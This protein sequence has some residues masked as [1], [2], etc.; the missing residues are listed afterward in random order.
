MKLIIQ[1]PCYNEENT[2]PETVNDL[3]KIIPELEKLGIDEVE[4][5]IIDDGS[6]D[7]TVEVARR[8]GIHHIVR[9]KQHKGLAYGFRAGVD[10]A[11]RLGADVLINTDADNQYKA[12]DVI[13]ILEPILLG[14]A[15]MVIGERPIE[16]IEHF[17]F[18]KKKLQRLGSKIVSL[19]A[20]VYIPD[21]TSGFR[22]FSREALLQIV[23]LGEYTYTLETIIQAGRKK[24]PIKSVPI[25]VNK[26]VLR[27][28][29]LIKS[30]P[31][32]I[33]RSIGAIF[34]TILIYK[35]LEVFFAIGTI[36]LLIGLALGIRY[37]YFYFNGQGE[38]HIQSLI[39]MT[40]LFMI[41]VLT[42]VVG[43]LA[44]LMG[45]QRKIQEET[46]YR[47]RRLER[48]LEGKKHDN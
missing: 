24:I 13:T 2:L 42:V 48:D 1:I 37:L 35:P 44:D 30:I 5:L 12:E 47:V 18:V 19:A 45:S 33:A 40:V 23:V 21:T 28:S 8:E 6:V 20:G 16:E 39:L 3:K 11:L 41:G 29:R 15:D 27:E 32:Y 22:A 17:S 43:L 10:A 14:E 4:F 46:L 38:G 36:P 25:R 9:L 26:N 34:R 31:Q 7:R